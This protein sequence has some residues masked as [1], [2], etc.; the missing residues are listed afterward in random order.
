[1]ACEEKI[2][3]LA[4]IVPT[5]AEPVQ[6]SK[7]NDYEPLT[8]VTTTG[9]MG[10]YSVVYISRTFVP[11]GIEITNTNYWTL[12]FEGNQAFTDIATRVQ[13]LENEVGQ[14][15]TN[16]PGTTIDETITQIQNLLTTIGENIQSLTTS[17]GTHETEINS[18]QQD[19]T[20]LE[21]DNTT[22]KNN[23]SSLQTSMTAAE[24]DI[25]SLQSTVNDN[26]SDISSLQTAINNKQNK[27]IFKTPSISAS[28]GTIT[29]Y[30]NHAIFYN[31]GTN[32][33]VDYYLY[34]NCTTAA[35]GAMGFNVT[36]LGF[37]DD[38]R[39]ISCTIGG[40]LANISQYMIDSESTTANTIVV[41]TDKTTATPLEF[42]IQIHGKC[43]EPS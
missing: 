16:H 32:W 15:T 2:S 4:K 25:S 11:N 27:L 18:L 3:L 7:N 19:V 22:N 17:V 10:D 9:T 42:N 20:A 14:W 39:T 43:N 29:S 33:W 30:S 26:T 35:D 24:D 37:L 40:L 5:V 1:M 8:M 38:N 6:W 21:S 41:N 12:F 13:S 28:T 36:P 23:I 31:D 34:A